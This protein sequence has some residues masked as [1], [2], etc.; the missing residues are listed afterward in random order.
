MSLGATIIVFVPGLALGS[1]LNTVASSINQ[2]RAR[3]RLRAVCPQ[4]GHVA[5][6]L[7]SIALFAYLLRGGKCARC[8]AH[9]G[10]RYPILEVA[11][12]FLFVACFTRFGFT[13][14]GFVA[15]MFCAVLLVL[16]AIDVERHILPNAI[17]VPA[18]AAILL[19][20]IVVAP[21]RALEWVVAAV[22]AAGLLLALALAWRGS[23][24]MGDVKLAFLLGAGLGAS[25]ILALVLGFVA[26]F[27]AA[28]VVI[29]SRGIDARKETIPIGPFLALGAIVALLI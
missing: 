17:V 28:A 15:A 29:A 12:G 2:G 8:G 13:G 23:L 20:D 19:A 1:M 9:R 24:G 14:R 5:S 22:F 16:A 3:L 10:L 21:G 6:L 7:E 25:V 27:V 18:G 4:C 11:T 26:A